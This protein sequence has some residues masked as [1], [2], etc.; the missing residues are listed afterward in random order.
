MARPVRSLT[1]LGH[2]FGFR[3]VSFLG[4]RTFG[5]CDCP[6]T[7]R[8]T[9]RVKLGISDLDAL[10]TTIHEILHAAHWHLSESHVRKLATGIARELWRT[11]WRLGAGAGQQRDMAASV[12]ALLRAAHSASD[13]GHVEA[14]SAD[15]ARALWRLGWRR[16]VIT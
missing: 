13:K 8:R 7:K 11:G 2:R 10:D 4:V 5:D 6:R 14:L 16:P 15:I 1:I 3:R 9:I 12:C